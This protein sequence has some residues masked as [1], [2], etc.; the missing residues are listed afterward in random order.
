MRRIQLLASISFVLSGCATLSFAPPQV[1]MDHAIAAKN[2]ETFFNAICTPEQNPAPERVITSDVE[3]ALLLINNYVLTYRCQRDRAAEGRQFF[4]VP[5]FLGSAGAAT[6]AAFGAG[7][8]VAIAAGAASATLDHTKQY[9]A[10]KEKAVVFTDGLQAML[11]IQ[12]EAVGVDPYTLKALSDAQ[13]DNPTATTTETPQ[14]KAVRVARSQQSNPPQEP[15]GTEI[16]VSSGRQYYEL[17]RSAL[18]SVEQVVAQRLS[19]AGT[20]FDAA[21]VIAEISALNKK[22]EKEQPG[23]DAKGGNDQTAEQAQ[24]TAKNDAEKEAGKDAKVAAGAPAELPEER[25]PSL[26]S[27]PQRLATLSDKQ[28][29][30]AVIKLAQLQTKLQ[31]C[32]VSAKV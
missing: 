26:M 28:V 29:G 32:V 14:E 23:A 19:A 9:Y 2:N 11:C 25:N 15:P 18:F 1:R 13:Q 8:A 22:E 5:A 31:K 7:P 27:A 21:G 30:Q 17:I 10:P 16:Y 12:N 6:A 24:A 3:G 4:E 20:P